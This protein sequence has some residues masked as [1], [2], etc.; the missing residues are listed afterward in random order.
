M[1]QES[2]CVCA[3]PGHPCVGGVAAHGRHDH[4]HGDGDQ[5]EDCPV[6]W[7][8]GH[9]EQGR[10]AVQVPGPQG[11]GQVPRGGRPGDGSPGI[12]PVTSKR[13][14]GAERDGRRVPA[15]SAG[16]GALHLQD[17]GLVDVRDLLQEGDPAVPRRERPSGWERD[18]AGGAQCRAGRLGGQ[19]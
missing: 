1:F 10:P 3:D 7:C 15:G 12:D 9:G 11:R 17:E 2:S 4:R 5:G 6:V 16:G 18:G 19:Q 14:V 13:S 8:P